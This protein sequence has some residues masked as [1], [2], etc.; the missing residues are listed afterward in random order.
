LSPSAAPAG[1][2]IDRCTQL[3]VL[4]GRRDRVAG[5]QPGAHGI[6]RGG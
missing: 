2:A 1:A 6:G 4:L 3:E 5:E